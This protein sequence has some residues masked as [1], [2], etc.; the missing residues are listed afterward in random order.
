MIDAPVLRIARVLYFS[1]WK[2]MPAW[3]TGRPIA[4]IDRRDT[5]QTRQPDGRR[6]ATLARLNRH[7]KKAFIIKRES[8]GSIPVHWSG[9]KEPAGSRNSRLIVSLSLSRRP[10]WMPEERRTEAS[11]RYCVHR[12]CHDDGNRKKSAQPNA[13]PQGRRVSCVAHGRRRI[14]P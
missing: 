14:P 13:A 10:R 12:Q 8:D 6:F 2:P 9:V 11:V 4:S 7:S 3:Q 5:R 1:K